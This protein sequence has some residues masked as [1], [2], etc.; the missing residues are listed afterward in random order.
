MD[1]VE[2]TWNYASR[3]RPVPVREGPGDGPAAARHERSARARPE[4]SSGSAQARS[5][6]RPTPAAPGTPADPRARHLTR[7]HVYQG[8]LRKSGGGAAW[9]AGRGE[10]LGASRVVRNRIA[11]PAKASDD[12]CGRIRP[13]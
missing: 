7:E 11:I 12:G 9:R 2:G 3:A 10:A 5:S 4:A 13:P 6:S 8:V 1:F